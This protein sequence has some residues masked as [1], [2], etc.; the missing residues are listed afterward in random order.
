MLNYPQVAATPSAPTGVFIGDEHAD[1]VHLV[2]LTASISELVANRTDVLFIEAFYAGA[3]PAGTDVASLAGYLQGR[4]FDHTKTPKGKA[5]LPVC[6][7]SLIERCERAKL[8]V[9]GVDVQV[10][11]AIASLTKGKAMKMIQWRTGAANDSWKENIQEQCGLNGWSRFALFGGRAHAKALSNRFG[12]R[13]TAQIWDRA[14][15]S[16]VAL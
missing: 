7:H 16:Y 11:H 2:Q 3:P 8:P 4:N 13:I 6:Y 12:A 1:L 9:L 10:P 14:Q 5:E 15:K